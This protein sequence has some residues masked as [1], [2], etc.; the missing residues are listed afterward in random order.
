MLLETQRDAVVRYGR[1]MLAADLTAG[2]SGNLSSIDRDRRL[3][4]I[5]PSGLMYGEITPKDVVVVDLEGRTVDGRHN[6]SSE[7]AFH[8]A[9]YQSRSDAGAVVHTHSVYAT[10]MAC[11]NREIPPVHY[12]IGFAGKKVP[13][14][15]Y[16]TFGT[17][18]LARNLVN[19]MGENYN[20]VL[21]ANHGVVTVGENLKAAYTAAESVEFVARIC[22]ICADAGEPV[23]LSET[24]ME[25]VIEKFKTYGRRSESA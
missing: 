14:A 13:V 2:S 24:E 20:G 4:A 3:I 23:V 6:P 17:R 15:P 11:L 19:T 18:A 8:L 10:A 9:L 25:R 12:L 22:L 7:L 5:S 1:E 16:A 21:L